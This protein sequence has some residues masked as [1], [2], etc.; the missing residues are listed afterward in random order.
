VAAE[1][2]ARRPMTVERLTPGD[3][4]MLLAGD[5]WPQEI[6]ALVVLDGCGLWDAD[7]ELRIDDLRRRIASRLHLVPRLRQVIVRPGRGLGGPIWVDARRF[8]VADHVRVVPVAAP[9]DE[10]ALLAC[11]EGLR[12]KRLDL[13]RP[14]WEMWFLTG[15]PGQRVGLFVKIHHAVADGMAAMTIVG[16]FLDGTDA[17]DEDPGPPWRPAPRPR[18]SDLVADVMRGHLR[19][20]AGTMGTLLHP[21]ASWHRLRASLPAARELLADD[22]PPE[23]SLDHDLGRDRRLAVLRCELS[24]LRSI[25]RV[26][27]ATVNDVLLAVIGGGLRTLLTSRGEALDGVWAPI[28]VPIAMRRRWRG[29]TSGNRVAQMAVPLPLE[30]ADPIDRLGRIAAATAAAKSRDRSAVGKLFRSSIA[31]WLVIKAVDRQR[32]NVCSANI[33]GPHRPVFLL[34]SRALEILPILPL[35]GRVSL[36]VG[37]VSY[38]GSFT[39]GVTA[40]RDA[41]PDLDVFV[42]GMK[43]ELN[44]LRQRTNRPSIDGRFEARGRGRQAVTGSRSPVVSQAPSVGRR[45]MP[46]RPTTM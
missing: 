28:Y 18:P 39:I 11:V 45:A 20:I 3:R 34:G 6:G 2:L 44:A 38:A 41:F 33:P 42:E 29:P 10:D 22:P 13:A 7:G 31:T 15:L 5:I 37:A 36:G 25:G 27:D 23:T 21:R 16:A 14:A 32:V 35:I 4:L 1:A 46:A 17:H 24:E 19:G 8:D 30:Q 40:D 26:R 43:R 9:G 12:R